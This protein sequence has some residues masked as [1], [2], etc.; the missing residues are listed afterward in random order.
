MKNKEKFYIVIIIFL[1]LLVLY[2][3]FIHKQKI[4]VNFSKPVYPVGNFSA[5]E[6]Q[7][8]FDRK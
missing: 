8:I 6:R 3:A 7:N 5:P 2:F 4:E 1:T